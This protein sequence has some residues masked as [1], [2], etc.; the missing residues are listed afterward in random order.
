MKKQDHPIDLATQRLLR[1]KKPGLTIPVEQKPEPQQEAQIP[2]FAPAGIS[3]EGHVTQEGQGVI[4]LNLMQGQTAA[5]ASCFAI[6]AITSEL[7]F[8]LSKILAEA[9]ARTELAAGNYRKQNARRLENEKRQ[10]KSN[11]IL[12]GL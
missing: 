11:I 9:G 6:V 7:A 5:D 8:E 1:G 3:T 10:G 4:Y 12:P 2:V